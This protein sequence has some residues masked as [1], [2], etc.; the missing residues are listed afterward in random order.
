MAQKLPAPQSGTSAKNRYSAVSDALSKGG[1]ATVVTAGGKPVDLPPEL[2]EVLAAAAREFAQG[3]GVVVYPQDTVLTAQEAAS[4]LGVSRPT[5]NR[6]LDSG[7]IPCDRPANHRRVKLVDVL[8]YKRAMAT[9]RDTAMTELLADAATIP[10]D[11]DGFVTTRRSA[12]PS[13]Y[14]IEVNR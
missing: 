6:I 4:L 11:V 8:A 5:M 1:A 12:N 10:G 14:P 9:Q 2:C 7:R 13:H 3:R